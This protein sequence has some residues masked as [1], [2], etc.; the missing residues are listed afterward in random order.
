MTL[1]LVLQA[2]VR[3]AGTLTE[4]ELSSAMR[5]VMG[6]TPKAGETSRV[7]HFFGEQGTGGE[8]SGTNNEE[9]GMCNAC[10]QLGAYLVPF[11]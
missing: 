1:I 9:R 2:D 7:L 3:E 11:V 8:R 4:H 5:S 10:R 6:T